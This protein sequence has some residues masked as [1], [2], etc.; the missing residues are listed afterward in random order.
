MNQRVLVAGATGYLGRYIVHDLLSRGVD[1]TV[2]VRDKSRV[3]FDTS[4]LSLIEAQVTEPTTLADACQGIDV[5]ISA[6]GIT[7]QKDGLTYMDVDYQ[8]NVNLIEVAKR[9]GVAQFIYISVLNGAQLR[10]L[11]IGAAKEKLVDYLK[12]SGLTSCI[13]R[14]NGFFSD[15]REFLHMASG[16]RVYLFGDGSCRLNPIHGEDLARVV[17]D[18]LNGVEREIRVGGPELLSQNEIAELAFQAYHKPARIVHL[19]DWLRRFALWTVRHVTSSRTYGPIEFFLTT[20]AMDMEAP[21]HG[22]HTLGD[23]FRQEAH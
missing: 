16:G 5:V 9:S 2:I 23:F 1:T 14:P 20:L 4:Q 6:V 13:V 10:H 8:A 7:R 17:V 21:K 15:M 22:R 12:A 11:K 19:P 18:A 3:P